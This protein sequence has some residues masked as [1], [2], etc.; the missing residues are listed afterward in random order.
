MNEWVA[1]KNKL[2]PEKAKFYLAYFQYDDETSFIDV[3]SWH[4][5]A[6]TRV[7]GSTWDRGWAFS[8]D[9]G[10]EKYITHWMELPDP[11]I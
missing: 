1:I 7:D 8:S 2:P 11:P 9:Q 5:D 6:G 3:I 10:D 4:H